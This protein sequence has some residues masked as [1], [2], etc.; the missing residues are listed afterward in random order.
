VVPVAM[1]V[2]LPDEDRVTGSEFHPR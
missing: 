2:G 1:R